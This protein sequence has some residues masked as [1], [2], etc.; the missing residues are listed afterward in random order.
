MTGSN[1]DPTPSTRVDHEMPLRDLRSWLVENVPAVRFAFARLRNP[2]LWRSIQADRWVR[3]AVEVSRRYGLADFAIRDG[4]AY[5]VTPRGCELLYV[6]GRRYTA[7]GMELREESFESDEL[8]LLIELSRDS[9]TVMDIG[10]NC[11]YVSIV[12]ARAL[13]GLRIHAFEPVPST[14]RTLVHNCRHNEVHDRVTCEL[15]AIGEAPGSMRMTSGLNTGNHLLASG[16]A[17]VTVAVETL[18]GYV[19][20][21]AIDRIDGI[22]CDVEGAELFVVRGAR[23]SLQRDRP[24]VLLEISEP[25]TVRQ[26]YPPEA[27]VQEMGELGY[28]YRV[29]D[30]TVGC[31]TPATDLRSDLARSVNFLF[32]HEETR[33]APAVSS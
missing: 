1:A 9:G 5:V 11:G 26:G 12:L 8:D 21:R 33:P 23:A 17:G 15:L 27:L 31:L 6:Q 20:R 2:R 14:Y 16:S 22:K 30:P 25:L 24:W 7:L 18:D 32:E 13:P 19:A 10:A 4:Q 29:L 3:G 28:S